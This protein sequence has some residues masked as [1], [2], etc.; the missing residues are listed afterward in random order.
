MA[1]EAA[2]SAEIAVT[3]EMLH[4]GRM[5]LPDGPI[6]E[7]SHVIA[8]YRAMRAAEPERPSGVLIYDIASDERR[9]VTQA[10]VD[11]LVEVERAYGELRTHVAATHERLVEK[12]RTVRSRHGLPHVG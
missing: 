10:D 9:P 2:D 3:D 1:E 12:V 8:I 4:Q 5:A 7:P 6:H 11:A